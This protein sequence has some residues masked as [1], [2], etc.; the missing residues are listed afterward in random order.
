MLCS[1]IPVLRE[2]TGG[3]A[4]YVDATDTDALAQA[5]REVPSMTV[6]A[7]AASWAATT[8]RW[9]LTVAALSA[10]YRRLDDDHCD[11]GKGA[12]ARVT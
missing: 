5:L 2:V 10:L 9:E 1:D 6:P 7:A 4:E 8:Y 3:Y 11:T 12:A